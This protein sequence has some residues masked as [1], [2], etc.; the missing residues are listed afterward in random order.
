MTLGPAE[1]L[2]DVELMWPQKDLAP[3]KWIETIRIT[4]FQSQ[5]SEQLQQHRHALADS[6]AWMGWDESHLMS[7]NAIDNPLSSQSQTFAS[8]AEPTQKNLRAETD[9]ALTAF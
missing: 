9:L 4:W 6:E 3:S 5:E 2:G 7:L 1:T 8:Q